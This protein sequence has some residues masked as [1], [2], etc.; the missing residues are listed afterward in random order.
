MRT[1][2]SQD[3]KHFQKKLMAIFQQVAHL[4]L[5]AIQTSRFM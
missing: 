2:L 5:R 4:V 3:K 1:R